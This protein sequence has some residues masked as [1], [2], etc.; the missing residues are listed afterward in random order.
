MHRQ[1]S[2]RNEDEGFTLIE[3]VVAMLVFAIIATGFLMT[4]TAGLVNTRDTRARVIAANLASQQIDLIRS[5][6]SVFD[7]VNSTSTRTLNGDTFHVR[8]STSWATS[9]GATATCEAGTAVGSLAYKQ[10]T[11]EVTWDNMPE[12]SDPVFADTSLTPRSKINDPS[13]GTVLV[14]VID[15]AGSGLAGV[16]VSLSPASVAT[17]TTDSDGCAY[18]LK[19]PAGTY[20]VSIALGSGTYVNDQQLT[21]PTA[22]VP[23]TAGSSSRVSFA[24]DKATTFNASYAKN[25][26]GTIYLPNNLTTTFMSSYGSFEADWSTSGTVTNTAAKS[27][28]RYPLPSGYAVVA[29]GYAE[30]PANPATSCLSPEPGHWTA[31]ASLVGTAPYPV[32]GLPGTAVSVDV[33]MGGVS[34]NGANGSGSYLKAVSSTPAGAGD[35]GCG[36]SAVMTYTFGSVIGSGT[37][38]VALPYGTWKLYRGDSSN[39][40]TQITSGITVSGSANATVTGGLV[41]LDP[42][43]AP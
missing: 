26:T 33:P 20:T 13:L 1:F 27:F 16:Q 39:Q 14:G 23:V 30:T 32:A 5:A 25:L 12:G 17:V 31:T 10:V 29:G 8:V 37:T 21:A 34:L 19:V 3:V 4:V 41:V 11:V 15:S 42:R 36:A 35:P 9:T 22:T 43:T 38:R 18:L 7:V 40:T 6:S 28:T 2:A 24:Y